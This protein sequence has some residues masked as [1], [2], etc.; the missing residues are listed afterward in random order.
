M[1]WEG[2]RASVCMSVWGGGEEG[3]GAGDGRGGEE[4][5]EERRDGALVKAI[6]LRPLPWRDSGGYNALGGSGVYLQILDKR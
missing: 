2:A 5:R 6:K 1:E 4:K 3:R